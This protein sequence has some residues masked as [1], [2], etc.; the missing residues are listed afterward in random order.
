MNQSANP[1][2][3]LERRKR[4]KSEKT[5]YDFLLTLILFIYIIFKYIPL[6]RNGIFLE[7]HNIKK[8]GPKA[9]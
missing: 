4:D 6:Y 1:N 2:C 9:I 3:T 8:I 7:E 5:L